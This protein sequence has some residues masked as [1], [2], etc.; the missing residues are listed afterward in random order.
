MSSKNVTKYKFLIKS[1]NDY[2]K[3]GDF[4]IQKFTGDFYYTPS[5]KGIVDSNFGF[6]QRILE[7]YA[8]HR[9]GRVHV[10]DISGD[11]QIIES[12]FGENQP[13]TNE[14][15]LR[16][17][18]IGFQEIVRD[19]I[20]DFNKIPKSGSAD[21][22]DVVFDLGDYQGPV[23]FCFSI[24]SGRLIVTSHEGAKA[25]IRHITD[26]QKGLLLGL[27]RRCL[28]VESDNA[29]KLMQYQLYK[30]NGDVSAFPTGRRVFIA[31]NAGISRN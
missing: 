25:G 10:K 15:R 3:I 6:V 21:E 18:D 16:I 7:H 23:Q 31:K 26:E 8:F 1:G 9:T 17:Q 4:V 19:I 2:F 11:Y 20:I 13:K 30:F 22:L 14:L 28:G 29:D 24:V 5:Q 12:G 27:D